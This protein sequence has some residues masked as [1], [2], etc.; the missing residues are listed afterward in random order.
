MT[1]GISFTLV[2]TIPE[3]RQ[4]VVSCLPIFKEAD[5]CSKLNSII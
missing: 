2:F 5:T 1:K 3:G 4:S